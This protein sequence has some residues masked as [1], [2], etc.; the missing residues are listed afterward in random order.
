MRDSEECPLRSFSESFLVM[1]LIKA[2]MIIYRNYRANFHKMLR[3]TRII[4]LIRVF[5]P[6]FIFF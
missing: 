6:E 3:Y 1:W 2:D 4:R 5:H